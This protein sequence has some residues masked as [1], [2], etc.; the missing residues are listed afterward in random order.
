MSTNVVK[1]EEAGLPAEL[2]DD[3]LSTAGEGID[4]NASELEIPFIRVAQGTSPQLKKSD[5]KHIAGLNQGDVF[6]T[7]T[8]EKWD[9]EKGIIV[10][11]CYQATVYPEFIPEDQ[12]GGYLGLIDPSDPR[13]NQ[14]TRQGAKEFLADGNEVIKTDQHYCLVVDEDGIFQKAIIDFK[15]TGLKV[16]RRWKTQIAMQKVKH[17]KTGEM[18]TPALFATMWKLSVVEESKTVDGSLRSW[19]NWS[20]EKVGF[21]QNK[22]LFNEAKKFRASI[23]KGEVKAAS[24][25][26]PVQNAAPAD[27]DTLPKDDD[28]P[29]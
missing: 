1:K 25:D 13:L 11:P 10:V 15:S 9:G 6:N 2:M 12:G 26:Q 18:E 29:F 14:S 24:E 17:P 23:T 27:K 5:A 4:F 28:I 21:V 7:L 8:K 19:Y 3:I 16:S 22:S 20:I